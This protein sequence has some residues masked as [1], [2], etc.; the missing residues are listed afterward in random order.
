MKQE[1]ADHNSNLESIQACY[2]SLG[3]L[4]I[5]DVRTQ[6]AGVLPGRLCSA[7]V[8]NSCTGVLPRRPC[9]CRIYICVKLVGA[10]TLS[11]GSRTKNSKSKVES[12]LSD[13]CM[14]NTSRAPGH[15][16]CTARGHQLPYK[17]IRHDMK[18]AG[19]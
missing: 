12:S 13:Y 6:L 3:V 7:C 18:S 16:E 19:G 1:A 10:F 8:L 5:V 15:L 9:T 17:N 2:E 14:G 4:I 11:L